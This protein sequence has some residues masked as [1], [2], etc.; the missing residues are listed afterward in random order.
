MQQLIYRLLFLIWILL[1]SIGAFA[2]AS[3]KYVTLIGD[4]TAYVEGEI[5]FDSVISPSDANYRSSASVLNK[6][7]SDLKNGRTV[8]YLLKDKTKGFEKVSPMPKKFYTEQQDIR[9]LGGVRWGRYI[10]IGVDYLYP[11]KNIPWREDF[12][13]TVDF[14]DCLLDFEFANNPENKIYESIYYTLVNSG[15]S[16]KSLS[17]GSAVATNKIKLKWPFGD[18]DPKNSCPIFLNYLLIELNEKFCLDC[19]ELDDLIVKVKDL[20]NRKIASAVVKTI[21]QVKESGLNTAFL[22]SGANNPIRMVGVT[23]HQSVMNVENFVAYVSSWKNV[24]LLGF[25]KNGSLIDVFVEF[26]FSQTGHGKLELLRFK[27][28]GDS[29]VADFF[30]KVSVGEGVLY[31]DYLLGAI[32]KKYKLIDD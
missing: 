19:K 15:A 1:H 28:E 22:A 31:S 3:K 10:G 7:I 24:N 2:D 27:Q 14:K 8:G 29:I 20:E 32:A 11:N 6:L 25:I 30:G 26:N 4:K 9:F 12:H 5:C 16:D 23:G 13:C 21:K 18:E 17:D